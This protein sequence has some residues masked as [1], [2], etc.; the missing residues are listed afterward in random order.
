[1]FGLM[2]RKAH[3]AAL[4]RKD[5]EAYKAWAKVSDERD[6]FREQVRD[7]CARAE[8]AEKALAEARA[9]YDNEHSDLNSA[10]NTINGMRAA[11]NAAEEI[12][13][14]LKPDAEKH[15]AKSARDAAQKKAKRAAAKAG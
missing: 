1:M 13:A 11:L 8:K 6:K 10:R 9:A 5:E 15:R 2:T 3:I 12:I 4:D 7:T 14:A